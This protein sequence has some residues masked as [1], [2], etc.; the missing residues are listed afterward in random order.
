MWGLIV[1]SPCFRFGTAKVAP[2][3]AQILIAMGLQFKRVE[4][5]AVCSD[6]NQ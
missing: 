4:E 6:E 1:S 3:Q 2:S 5:T